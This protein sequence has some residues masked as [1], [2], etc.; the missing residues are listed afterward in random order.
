MAE[1]ENIPSIKP[2]QDDVASY[3]RSGRSEAPKQSNFNGMLVFVIVLMAIMMGVGGYTIYELQER[4]ARS[5]ELLEQSK[6]NIRQ[7]D[8]RLAA[9][10][11]DVSKTFQDL[12][13]Q[14]ETNFSEIDK[15]WA[16]S[17]RQ[18]RPD[19]QKNVRAIAELKDD[20]GG[21][22]ITMDASVKQMTGQYQSMLNELTTLREGLLQDNEEL[23][24][25][26]ALLRGQV[27]DQAVAQEAEKRNL[28]TLTREMKETQEAID[29]IDQYR[30]QINQRL[31][32]LQNQIQ[33]SPSL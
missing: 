19:I 7:L 30:L 6:E 27:Q 26:I 4:L 1:N 31:I 12:K 11:T 20:L 5:D 16:V 29:S 22:M 24:T 18:N 10:G 28:N 25:E 17:Y 21:K 3:R 32:E 23:I 15:L 8:S 33:G 14:V 2:D 13:A 9:T